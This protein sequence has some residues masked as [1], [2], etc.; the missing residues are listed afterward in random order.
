MNYKY[1]DSEWDEMIRDAMNDM[2]APSEEELDEM[3]EELYRLNMERS[4]K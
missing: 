3:L 2:P 4:S 1:I